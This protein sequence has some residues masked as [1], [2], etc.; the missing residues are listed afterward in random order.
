MIRTLLCAALFLGAVAPATA[1]SYDGLCLPGNECTG[2]VPITGNTFYTCEENCVM[3]KPTAV[4]GMDAFLFDVTCSG[5]SGS[6][7]YRMMMARIVIDGRLETYAIRNDEIS[8]LV[9]C[10]Q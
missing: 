8:R 1:Q 5:D 3:E 10:Q 4:R 6:F 2:P 7:S 9:S